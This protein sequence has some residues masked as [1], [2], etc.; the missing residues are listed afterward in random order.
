MTVYFDPWPSTLA[1]KTV[2][3]RPWPS[4]FT[5]LDRPLWT[6]L[7][8]GTV[9]VRKFPFWDKTT[10]SEALTVRVN[11]VR[12]S[13]WGSM[14]INLSQKTVHL[15][16]WPP[17]LTKKDRLS[18]FLTV[19]LFV[20]FGPDSIKVPFL[21]ESSRFGIKLHVVRVNVH[22]FIPKDRPFRPSI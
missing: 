4:T 7:H 2:H 6:R 22:R 18:S 1:Q 16:P 21:S 14:C 19:Y 20:H 3:Y 12:L 10:C 17:T 8:K 13:L 5:L 15:D 11:V 9:F